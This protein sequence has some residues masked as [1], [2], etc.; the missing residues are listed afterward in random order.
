M[1]TAFIPHLPDDFEA[2]RATLHAYAQ[3]VGA[4]PRAHGIA[5]PKWWHI[6][7]KPRPE[8]LV[9]DPIP[10]PGG[11]SLGLTMDLALHQVVVRASGGATHA[12]D[13]RSG[14]TGTE[15]ADQLIAAA[16]EHGLEGGY[17]RDKFE[18]DDPAVYDPAAAEAFGVGFGNAAM[19]L[20]RHRAALG[21]RVGPIQVWPHGF[22]L[23]FEWFG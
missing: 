6:S 18:S 15:F 23:A 16:E 4:I 20:A 8:G 19:V 5:H 21:T 1:P 12:F 17:Q 10:L 9:T 3:G 14:A 22:D 11:G 13:L 7:L 2:T